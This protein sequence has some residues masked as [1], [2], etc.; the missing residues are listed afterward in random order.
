MSQGAAVAEAA[1]MAVDEAPVS[2]ATG[3]PAPAVASSSPS[4]SADNNNATSSS[5]G[6]ADAPVADGRRCVLCKT[7]LDVPSTVERFVRNFG[8]RTTIPLSNQEVE[9]NI[10]YLDQTL[11]DLK[12]PYKKQGYWIHH[13]CAVW[14]PEVSENRLGYAQLTQCLQRA[15]KVFCTHC[16]LPGA[17]VGCNVPECD[18]SLHFPCA[19]L[20]YQEDHV[21]LDD[22]RYVI[23][24][25]DHLDRVGKPA[26]STGP[27]PS[28]T[29]TPAPR[30][31]PAPTPPT[32]KVTPA[33]SKPSQSREY[34]SVLVKAKPKVERPSAGQRQAKSDKSPK[35][36]NRT[37]K[38]IED[39]ETAPPAKKPRP[40]PVAT[41]SVPTAPP[42]SMSDCT[43]ES[44]SLPAPP[45]VPV[46]AA[47]SSTL[48]SIPIPEQHR[49]PSATPTAALT[50]TAADRRLVERRRLLAEL[51]RTAETEM[52]EG[53]IPSPIVT[54]RLPT[55]SEAPKPKPVAKKV[56]APAPRPK[57]TVPIKPRSPVPQA[58][59]TLPK[60]AA[61]PT[62]TI[63]QVKAAPSRS[64]P[65]TAKTTSDKLAEAKIKKLQNNN[66]KFIKL[67]KTGWLSAGAQAV[68]GTARQAFLHT[69]ENVNFEDEAQVTK[70]SGI[71]DTLQKRLQEV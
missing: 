59:P 21:E 29:P 60:P 52:A 58:K 17:T 57:P 41:P 25:E 19:F 16:Q 71:L 70:L 53:Y 12:G 18:V 47:F 35:S 48:N 11:G 23:Y 26:P 62:T 3:A 63:A 38:V 67:L 36:S 33:V 30:L 13:P 34:T 31:T 44:L 9:T 15:P 14:S 37:R 55:P 39:N 50:E 45:S 1:P 61:A 40:S 46:P 42:T 7:N 27:R 66:Q 69:M 51:I 4:A 54:A 28:P 43:G 32:P 2:T 65:P 24:C 5:S 8:R 20:L 49:A 10:D 6:T 22:D 56:T 64:P 68:D